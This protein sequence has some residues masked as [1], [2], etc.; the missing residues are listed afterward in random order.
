MNYYEH[1]FIVDAQLPDD[2]IQEKVKKFQGV[3]SENGG[4]IL[5]LEE[6][7]TRRLAYEIRKKTQG[8]YVFMQ[9]SAPPTM[10]RELERVLRLDESILRYLTIL[11]D[12]KAIKSEPAD[13]S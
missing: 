1:I 4:E 12:E 5:Y 13:Q 9:F 10:I 8:Y 3:V 6:W 7:G 11:I 2:V